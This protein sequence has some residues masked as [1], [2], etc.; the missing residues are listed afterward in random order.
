MRFWP[1]RSLSRDKLQEIREGVLV[2][3]R[4]SLESVNG[5]TL[6]LLVTALMSPSPDAPPGYIVTSLP[7][8]YHLADQSDD[9]WAFEGRVLPLLGC[10]T[11]LSSSLTSWSVLDNKWE[12]IGGQA[13][14]S[15]LMS[16]VMGGVVQL[17]RAL[18]RRGVIKGELERTAGFGLLWATAWQLWSLAVP[19][20]QY[21]S[22]RVIR[23]CQV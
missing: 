13:L 21:V 18:D 4:A 11:A 23:G 17:H 19:F 1:Y 3:G 16:A 2:A 12:V 10:A 14:F 22:R 8:L 9:S 20:G 15:G 6:F 7:V 5:G